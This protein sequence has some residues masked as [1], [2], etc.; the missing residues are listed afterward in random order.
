MTI[1]H[2]K[3]TT[4]TITTVLTAINNIPKTQNNNSPPP[5]TWAQA[6]SHSYLVTLS[7]PPIP[8]EGHVIL[9]RMEEKEDQEKVKAKTNKEIL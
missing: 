9:I 8:T 4:T 1:I 5:K 2:Q 7:L 6:A 3:E